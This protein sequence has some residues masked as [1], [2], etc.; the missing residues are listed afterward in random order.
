MNMSL[1]YGTVGLRVILV[2]NSVRN[3]DGQTGTSERMDRISRGN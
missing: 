3:R 1:A 2:E